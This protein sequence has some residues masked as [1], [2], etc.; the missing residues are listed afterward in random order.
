MIRGV[1][2][3]DRSSSASWACAFVIVMSIVVT[4]MYIF[5][6]AFYTGIGSVQSHS[7]D[8]RRGF[9][10]AFDAVQN[11]YPGSVTDASSLKKKL[12]D[13]APSVVQEMAA[14]V[15]DMSFNLLMFAL[16]SMFWLFEPLPIKTPVARLFKSYLLLKTV[17]CLVFASMM[18]F[19]M[20]MLNCKIWSLFFIL[21][22]VLNYLP[23]L[24]AIASAMLM[25]P[26]VLFDGS[27]TLQER[28]RNAVLLAVVGSII[29]I[30]TGNVIEVRLYATRGGQFMRMHPIILMAMMMVCDTLLGLTGMFLSVP[31]LAAVKFFLITNGLPDAFLDPTLVFIEG[32]ETG[33]LKN[34]I[35]RRKS[36]AAP[37]RR[38]ISVRSEEVE[39][40]RR[41]SQDEV[42]PRDCE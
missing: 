27:Q 16:Y 34:L 13:M 7:A 26:A 36:E 12:E 35:D 11:M 5:Y 28:Q 1:L 38:N 3:V 23:E 20:W 9:E 39:L 21:T 22:F 31:I 15:E 32:D 14:V 17:V 29:K 19:L 18:S 6:C 42:E 4:G 2:N 24:G 37:K 41:G 30:F 40:E 10:E 33:P 25:M 8:Y